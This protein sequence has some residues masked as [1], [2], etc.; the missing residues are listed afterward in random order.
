MFLNLKDVFLTEGS[1]KEFELSFSM[2]DVDIS[3]VFPFDSP[4]M[5]KG[6]ALNKAGLIDIDFDITFTYSRPCDR[7]F[8]DTSRQLNYQFSHRLIDS[9]SG[10][11]NDDYIEIPD[12]TLDVDELVQSDIIL[13]LPVKFLCRED[14][15]GICP[16]CGKNLNTGDCDCKAKDIDPRLEALKELLK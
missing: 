10:S 11:D 13:N 12:Y 16:K 1:K 9:L 7:C 3:G 4:V 5:V 8:E 14:C 6:V 2:S 15:K